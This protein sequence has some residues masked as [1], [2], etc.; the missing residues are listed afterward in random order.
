MIKKIIKKLYNLLPLR[1][2]NFLK[3]ILRRNVVLTNAKAYIE[4][5][6]RNEPKIEEIKKQC[7]NDFNLKPK[8]SLV[9]PMY[10]TDEMFFLELVNSLK[11]QTYK[12]WEACFADGSP[13]QN[14]EIK[15]IC[16]TDTRIKYKFINE[17][18]GISGNSNEAIS[19]ATG[20]YIGLLDHDDLLPPFALYEMVKAINELPE[21]EFLYSD[22]D[23]IKFDNK[24]N[25]LVRFDPNFK[26]DFAPD[27]LRSQ[28]YICHFSVMKKQLMDKL[29]GFRSEFD[30]SQ[31]FDL[32]LRA[33]ELTNKIV[34]IPKILY[35]WRVHQSSTAFEIGAKEYTLDAGKKAIEAHLERIGLKGKVEK[36]KV[37]QYDI[38]YDVLGSP[39]VTILIPNKDHIETLKVCIDSIL[40]QTTYQNY[41]IIIIENNSGEQKTFDYYEQLIKNPKINVFY[42]KEKV[43]NYSKIINFGVNSSNADYIVQLNNDIEILTKDWLERMISFAQREDVGA[44]G[45]KLLYP[46]KTVQHAG[47]ILG[48]NGVAGHAHKNYPKDHHG[49]M[50]RLQIIQN[51][52]AVTAACIMT[53]REIYEQVGFMDEKFAVAF[54]DVDFC[55]KIRQLDK[56]IVYNPLI[57]LV[58]YE[59]KSRGLEDTIEKQKRFKGEID[60]FLERWG[61]KLKQGDPYY[62]PNLTLKHEDFSIK[63]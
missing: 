59:S 28:N 31:D 37:Y 6:K 62:N 56:L 15:K 36:N 48:I 63:I 30:G 13:N 23:K 50:S 54:N 42:F 33:S 40:A 20:E 12:N 35:H 10:N 24:K 9:I 51:L 60:L 1:V 32:F 19:L 2:K 5:I 57:E 22:E 45:V 21:A 52:S 3:R 29:G 43:F 7:D 8:I 34:H 44:V 18:K 11:Q 16:E 25:K 38:Q 4:W 47:V 39:T 17:N 14:L 41:E 26:P 55:M 27:T 46:D 53:K 61:E 49:Y 58:H